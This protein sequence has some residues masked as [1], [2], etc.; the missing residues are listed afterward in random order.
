MKKIT[1]E[2]YATLKKGNSSSIKMTQTDMLLEAFLLSG[3]EIVEIEETD[4][5][6]ADFTSSRTAVKAEKQLRWTI[7]AKPKYRETIKL[8]KRGNRLFLLRR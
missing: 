8:S 1:M 3:Q 4:L 2:E 6:V 5:D 7:H